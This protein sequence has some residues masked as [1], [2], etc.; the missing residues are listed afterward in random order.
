MPLHGIEHPISGYYDI[1]HGDGL[2]ALL[3]AWMRYTSSVRKE[4]FAALGRDVF[5][6]PD[7]ILATEGWLEKVGMKLRLRELG[8]EPGRIRGMADSALQTTPSLKSYPEWLDAGAIAQIY[9]DAY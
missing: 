6:R 4:R 8:I 3:P 5:A 1:A 7:G 9:Q 2:A